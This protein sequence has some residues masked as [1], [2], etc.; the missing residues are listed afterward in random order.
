MT[1]SDDKLAARILN[2]APDIAERHLYASEAVRD[3][4]LAALA[5][6]TAEGTFTMNGAGAIIEYEQTDDPSASHV[7]NT[8]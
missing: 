5:A 7:T 8:P 6:C 3:D 4:L 2:I 1:L